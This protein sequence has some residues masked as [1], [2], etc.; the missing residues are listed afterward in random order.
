MK[1]ILCFVFLFWAAMMIL[2]ACT[3][4]PDIPQELSKIPLTAEEFTQKAEAAGFNVEDLPN[5]WEEGV[6]I[7]NCLRAGKDGYEFYFFVFNSQENTSIFYNYYQS[8]LESQ[9][10]LAAQNDDDFKDDSASGENYEWY[11]LTLNEQDSYGMYSM[12]SRI[13][14]TMIMVNEYASNREALNLII[15]DL[16]Y[17]D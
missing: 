12:Y 14:S 6:G 16:G 10:A 1:K 2:T 17:L 15:K 5:S 9:S 8:A 3:K 11:A 7:I 13:D 4:T